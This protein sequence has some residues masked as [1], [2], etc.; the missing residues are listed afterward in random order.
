MQRIVTGM[1]VAI[2]IGHRVEV[3][4]FREEDPRIVDLE[5]GVEYDSG[6]MYSNTPASVPQRLVDLEPKSDLQA[7]GALRGTVRRCVVTRIGDAQ[8]TLLVVEPELAPPT[9]YR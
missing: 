5:T 9:A 8:Q 6:R 1:L 4:W 3:T 2:P 7:R